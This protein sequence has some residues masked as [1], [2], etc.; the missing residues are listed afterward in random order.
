LRSIILLLAA[1]TLA[2]PAAAQ[3]M[4]MSTFHR[5]NAA[6]RVVPPRRPG[7]A[8]AKVIIPIPLGLFQVL[9]D[10]TVWDTDSSY[11]NPIQLVDYILHPPIYL[12]VKRAPTPTND[13]EFYI[14]QN[15]LIIDL[16]ESQAVVPE[17]FE[18]GGSVRPFNFGAGMAGFRVAVMSWVHN[19]IVVSLDDSL[20]AVL[21]E[22]APVLPNAR[23]GIGVD[24][25]LQGG[26]APELSWAGRVLGDSS[27]GLYVGGATRYYLGTMY[28]A[29]DGTAGFT[30]GDTIFSAVNPLT[31]DAAGRLYKTDPE[32]AAGTGIGVDVGVVWASGPFEVGLGVTD[33]GAT[34]TWSHTDVDT[35]AWDGD[36]NRVVELPL[37]RG[38][39]TK[40]QLPV[41]AI[42][43]AVYAFPTGT[44]LRGGVLRNHRGTLVSAG[45]E[46]W[47]GVFTVRGGLVRDQRAMIQYAWG[48]GVRLGPVGFD[49]GFFT[50]S[51]SLSTERGITMSTTLSIY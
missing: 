1:A 37:E 14:A 5:Y 34:I 4:N 31:E 2:G 18:L 20:R 8:P 16:G 35:L 47:L 19:E 28:I 24:G 15:E 50:H 43:N 48:G 26:L 46:Q 7:D 51:R 41:T 6:Y 21:K 49:V 13:V 12:E 29:I 22:A 45:A 25:L 10:S 44:V 3:V 27:A 42:A 32:P 9:R 40:T 17:S 38:V 11:Y 33:I 39:E 30:T 23:Y 36:S